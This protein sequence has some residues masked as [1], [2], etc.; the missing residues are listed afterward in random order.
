M[1]YAK[2]KAALADEAASYVENY[3]STHGFISPAPFM[4]WTH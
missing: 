2:S 4:S 3:K 1:D